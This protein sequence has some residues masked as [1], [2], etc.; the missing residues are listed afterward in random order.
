MQSN[1]LIDDTEPRWT[2]LQEILRMAGPAIV[3]QLSWVIMQFIDTAMVSRLGTN[4]LAAVG[5]AGLW[6]WVVVS[7]FIGLLSCVSTFVSQSIGRGQS[8]DCARYAWQGVYLALGTALVG[9]ALV[10]IARP[11]FQSMGHEP[12]VTEYELQYFQ[13]RLLGFF[14]LPWQAV[15]AGFFLGIN[16]PRIPMVAAIFANMIN[17]GLGYSLIFGRFGFPRLEVRGAAIAMMVALSI[18]CVLLQAIYLSQPLR[19][20]FGTHT[21]WKIDLH[22]MG[23]LVRIGWGAGITWMLDVITWGVF[24]SF[25]VGKSGSN[26]LAAHNCAISVMQVSFQLAIGLNQSIAPIVGRWIGKGRID[27]A[28]AR[29]YTATRLAVGYMFAMGIVFAVFGKGLLVLAFRANPEVATI[30]HYLLIMAAIFQGF[31]AVT[32]VM[33]GA[34]RGAGD[35]KWQALVMGTA[36][37]FVFLPLAFVLGRTLEWGAFGAWVGATIYIIS[38]SGVFYYRFA[39][40][41][42]R[43]IEIFAQKKDPGGA[44]ALTVERDSV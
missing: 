39:G 8:Q 33:S 2:G 23:E 15:L 44:D 7:F 38:L 21:A 42:W 29:T 12:G 43:H 27:R 24:T 17:I 18:Q 10:P 26:A 25:I 31:D 5:S 22:R 16:R 34:L 28:K 19:A 11:F 9:F 3:A 40:E 20:E 14:L 36:A 41:K 30:G 35:T 13:L 1:Q 32:I 4:Q 37:Y 6:S